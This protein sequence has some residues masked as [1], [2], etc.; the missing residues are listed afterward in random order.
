MKMHLSEPRGGVSVEPQVYPCGKWAQDTDFRTE[1][2]S[3]ARTASYTPAP[4][5]YLCSQNARLVGCL[6][7]LGLSVASAIIDENSKGRVNGSLSLT[8]EHLL[9]ITFGVYCYRDLFPLA[10]FT[11][12]PLDLK[13]G[14]IIW[15]KIFILTATAVVIPLVVPREYVPVDPGNPMA[16]PNPEQTASLL[17]LVVYA[18][19]DPIIFLAYR[20]P[21]FSH[22]QLPPLADYDYAQNLRMKSFPVCHHLFFGLMRIFRREYC[23]LACMIILMVVFSFA[24][25][26][27][28]NRLLHY[29]E[30]GGEDAFIRPWVWVLWLFLGP[31][32][33]S[34][35]TQWYSY[36]VTHTVV[37]AECIITQLVFEH[38]LRIRVKAETPSSS[39]SSAAAANNLIGKINNLVTTDL[40]NIT[41]SCH[42]LLVT[43]YLPLQIILCIW[44]LYV[45][46][47][48]RYRI[49]GLG[50]IL[51][52]SPSARLKKT[53]ARVQTVTETMNVLRMIKLFG[54][55]SKINTRVAEKRDE[56][57]IWIWKRQILDLINDNI[58]LILHMVFYYVNQSMTGKVS[59]DRVNDF[60]HNTELLDSFSERDVVDFLPGDPTSS[61]L[62]GFRD[63]T[64][65]WSDDVAGSLTPS[66][67]HFSLRI[68]GE[69]IFKPG[70]VNLIVGPTG[71]GKTSLLMALLGE[72]HFTPSGPNSWFNLPRKNGIAYA[73]QESWVQNETIRENILFGAPF[74][75]ERYK[76]VLNQCCLE[77]DLTLF[78]AGDQ[79]EVG[80][81]G[82]TLSG[83]QKARVTLARAIYSQAQTILLDDVLAALDVHT[84]KWIVDKCFSGDLIQGRTILLV[85]HNV[86]MAEPIADF[87]VSLGLDG[88]IASQGSITEA[89][90]KNRKLAMELSREH[91]ALRKTE[92]EV[93]SPPAD[94]SKGGKLI[95]AEEIEEGHISWAALKL[96]L[97][98]LGGN[99]PI[100][101][102]LALIRERY[103]NMVSG[104]WASQYE[105]RSGSEVAIVYYI[106]VYAYVVYIFG[107][108]RASRSVHKQLIE[109]VLGTT[110]RWLDTTPTS[111]VIT[112]FDGPISEN[113]WW[114]SGMTTSMVIKFGAVVILTPVFLGPG[115]FVALMGGWCGQIYM[116]A[117]LPVKREMS[118]AKAPVLG[119]FG[120]AMSGLTSIRAYGAQA[121]FIE[122]SLNRIN[123]YTR[124]ARTSWNLNRWVCV[125]IDSM[126]GLFSAALAGYLVYFQSHS[127]SNTGFSL[128][129]AV[130]FS[131]MILWW[132]RALNDFE[133]QGILERIHGYVKIEQEPKPTADGVPPAYWPASGELRVEDLSARYSPDGPKVL[134]N[135][136][137]TIQA[138]QR[139]SLTLS[140]LRCI[141]TDGEVFYDGIR[142]DTINLDA[143]RSSIT[144]IPQTPELLS[145]TLRQNLDP[146]DQYDDATLND[147]LRAAGLFSLQSEMEEGRITLDSSVSSGGGNLSVGQ[148]QILALA[149]AIVRGSKLLILDEDYK[150]DSVIQSSL[151]NE[152][153]SDVTLITVAHRLQ[154]IMDADKIM[155]LDAGHIVEFDSPK[156]LLQV[157]GGKL[158]ALV[159]ESGD[160]AALYAMAEKM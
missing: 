89:L 9:T 55:E 101:F 10:T 52:L 109:S 37:Q 157:E 110:L 8:P 45:V 85:T 84:A 78:E 131:G 60:L 73:A 4:P 160:K 15:A 21:H 148:R 19:L 95:V 77:R 5:L 103:P 116:A 63:A 97:A 99:H 44:F 30:S 150:T 125:R 113:L 51:L 24:S 91:H 100:I 66:K 136:S 49:R 62:I 70:C 3:I 43:L 90:A 115:I 120:A 57:L 142:T 151:R 123:R 42:F 12:S 25:P 92:E 58:K 74:D 153:N 93:D 96:Y 65:V 152:L 128:N 64:F 17:S 155:V 68:E 28:I 156:A 33:R 40:G 144:I 16:T 27:G 127:A 133:V 112:R 14:W 22:D 124:V 61:D 130:G 87:V 54:W 139:S 46:L 38:A 6:A 56:E 141:F 34:I 80:E 107:T 11:R 108:L 106:S 53:D 114:L 145:G 159:D 35:S 29:L 121:S 81:K 26:L 76:K 117:Q 129:M 79:T 50:V 48:W 18:F 32:L 71:S 94:D 118:N 59:L 36:I 1:E 7:L 67:R 83:G 47:G 119:H 104:L 134:H 75:E 158:R 31:T 135:V 86:A 137:F 132:V 23:I 88:R 138:G 98:G 126:G 147:A 149:R 146:F 41:D 140:L 13:E 82:L 111:R 122:E 39:Q 20:I 72:M 102:F 2:G 69:L 154:T 143:L 105:K